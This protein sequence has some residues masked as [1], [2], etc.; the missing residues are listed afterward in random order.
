M[1]SSSAVQPSLETA[2]AID[3]RGKN[4]HFSVLHLN[5]SIMV[6]KT[7]PRL[8]G[9]TAIAEFLGQTPAVAQRWHYEG[10]PV[11]KE[12]RFV[13]ADPDEVTRWVGTDSG[14]RKPVHIASDDENLTADLKEGLSYIRGQ[15]KGSVS[16]TRA[17][18]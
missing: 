11:M 5:V 3:G 17:V 10:M 4:I 9:W 6:K 13:Y 15:R 2:L 14:K 1:S 8:K 18:S 12:G 7:S 16:K